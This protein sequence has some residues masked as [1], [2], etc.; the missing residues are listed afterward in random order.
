MARPLKTEK[1]ARLKI[2]E[3]A[4]QLFY[5]QGYFQTGINQIIEESGISKATFYTHF[6][7][8][9]ELAETYLRERDVTELDF[10]EET[11]ADHPTGEEKIKA[12]FP[13]M[14][15][16]QVKSNFRGCGFAN[17]AVEV[18][19]HE[20]ALR[21]LVRDHDTKFRDILR[22]LVTQLAEEHPHRLAG[23]DLESLTNH[24]YLLVEGAIAASQ[25]YAAAWPIEQAAELTR[26]LIRTGA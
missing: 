7:T 22:R 25:H 12:L 13:G 2:I 5:E 10:V 11:L 8:K 17:I 18:A 15:D 21:S 24:L 9:E 4:N 20:S 23:Q 16:W 3:A 6:K 19:D 26:Q 1:P 14:M